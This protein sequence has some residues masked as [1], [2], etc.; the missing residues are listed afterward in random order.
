MT[1]WL[2]AG[3]S[4]KVI[5]TIDGLFIDGINTSPHPYQLGTRAGQWRPYGC[6][7]CD[8]R[9]GAEIHNPDRWRASVP[10]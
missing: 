1:G 7:Q 4:S 6:K 9:A 8:Q 3:S 2:Y 5:L 10:G